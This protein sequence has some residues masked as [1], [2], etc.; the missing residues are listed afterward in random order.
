MDFSP[1]FSTLGFPPFVPKLLS[2][3][4]W[5]VLQLISDV[6]GQIKEG[7]LSAFGVRKYRESNSS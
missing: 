7:S 3:V 6:L 4:F 2:K 1:L 5:Q